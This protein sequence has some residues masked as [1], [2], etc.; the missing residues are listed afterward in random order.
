[1]TTSQLL[2]TQWSFDPSVWGG[3]ALLI[4]VH[5]WRIRRATI[6][7]RLSWIAG[8]V[9]MFVAL[10]SALDPLS[11]IYLFSAHMAQ[12]LL[13]ILI[14]PP[15]LL[16]GIPE[17]EARS[18]MRH[19]AI[20]RT[21]SILGRPVLAWCLGMGVMTLWHVP[22]LYDYAVAHETVHICE[23]LSFLVTATIFW[24]PIMS[25]LPERRLAPVPAIFY[26]FAA[27]A[28]NSALG[29]IITFM[30]VGYY[31]S[32]L[33]PADPLHILGTIRN[34]WGLSVAADQRLG[35]LLMWIPG[36]T[37]YF[38]GILLVFIAWCDASDAE[39]RSAP[40][41]DSEKAVQRG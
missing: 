5:F 37:I 11:D 17:S 8:V 12:H 6:W 4:A 10:E 28:E 25:P 23:H 36:C 21:E 24:W 27:V 29:I 13:L 35:G 19:P 40:A 14:V 32:Y 41:L 7:Q 9:T 26:L 30:P 1:M 3:C 15:F 20:R 18:W 31:H 39:E 2:L 33:H 16:W 38:I 34:Q 22:V